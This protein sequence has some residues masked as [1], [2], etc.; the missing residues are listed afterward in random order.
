[1]ALNYYTNQTATNYWTIVY[2]LK[3]N[4]KARGW[5]VV[6]S[7]TGTSGTYNSSGDSITSAGTASGTP[8]QLSNV[9]TWFVIQDPSGAGGRQFCFSCNTVNRD[10]LWRIKYSATSGFSGGSPS[11]TQV[12]SAADEVVL[13]GSGTDASPT[14]TNWWANASAGTHR[15]QCIIDD[16]APYPFIL[17]NYISGGNPNGFFGID[18]CQFPAAGDVDPIVIMMCMADSSSATTNGNYSISSNLSGNST[19]FYAWFRKGLSGAQFWKLSGCA[20]KDGSSNSIF[21]AGGGTNPHTV[22]DDLV[23]VVYARHSSFSSPTGY[24]GVSKWFQHNSATR[25]NTDTISVASA[26]AKDYAHFG[27]LVVPWNGTT[28][29]T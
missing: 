2:A 24:K 9:N 13:L 21:P 25:T 19:G 3:E 22:K 1:M 17:I 28:P 14:M 23:P 12:P 15:W 27:V 16:A 20:I 6:R 18:A 10:D 7:G 29:V 4:L 11:A 5:T 8:G 26:G